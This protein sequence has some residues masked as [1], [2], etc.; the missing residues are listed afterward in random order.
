MSRMD[1]ADD[2]VSEA[3]LVAALEA[4]GGVGFWMW[5]IRRDEARAD[6]VSALLF[7]IS[8]ARSRAGVRS[9]LRSGHVR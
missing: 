3:A 5:D 2:V 7:N 9:S 8:P 6:P 1:H 4:S